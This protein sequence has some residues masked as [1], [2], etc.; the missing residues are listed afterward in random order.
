MGNKATLCSSPTEAWLATQVCAE[1]PGVL[2]DSKW[3]TN[4]SGTSQEPLCRPLCAHGS[5][6]SKPREAIKSFVGT[7]EVTCGKKCFSLDSSTGDSSAKNHRYNSRLWQ[8]RRDDQQMRSW[9]LSCWWEWSSVLS[10]GGHREH[11][12]TFWR[13]HRERMGGKV[14]RWS[15]GNSNWKRER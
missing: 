13:L 3:S 5:T 8:V 9:S 4:Q 10:S 11:E 14:T 1:N 7:W 2:E 12:G 15:K 6:V